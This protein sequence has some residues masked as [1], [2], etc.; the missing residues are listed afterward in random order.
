MT[1]IYVDMD[2]VIA[3]FFGQIS[4]INN[5]EHW[6]QISDLTEALGK[7]NGTDFFVTLPKF[8]T[9]DQLVQFVKKITNN[10][11]YI[12]SS[13][14]EG[15]IF[16][17]SFWKSYWLKN[18]NYEPIEAIYAEDK[19]KYAVTKNPNILID[20]R[21]YNIKEWKKNGG[22]GILYQANKDDFSKLKIEITKYF[23]NNS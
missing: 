22:I 3:D 4:K 5:V 9:S 20:D 21:P 1:D 16:N 15:D 12:L 6:K 14:L 11:W 18:N 13:P 10:H 17:S 7:L 23:G 19:Y 8:K 2:G